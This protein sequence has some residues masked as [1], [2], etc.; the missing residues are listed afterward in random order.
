MLHQIVRD[1]GVTSVMCILER[2]LERITLPSLH[3]MPG[4]ITAAD[5]VRVDDLTTLVA[6]ALALFVL[7][8]LFGATVYAIGYLSRRP[9]RPYAVT[10]V[11]GA[12][13]LLIYISSLVE[14]IT[15][16]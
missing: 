8:W 4:R 9:L 10:L 16:R 2:M 12:V 5:P 15:Q 1:L 6:E 13:L 14:F 7:V 3:R 11:A